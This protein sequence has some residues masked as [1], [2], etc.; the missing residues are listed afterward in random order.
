MLNGRGSALAD[1]AEVLVLAGQRAEATVEL[2]RAIVLYE[3]K[4]N[5]V[6]AE[7]LRVRLEK[8]RG[9]GLTAELG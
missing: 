6:S 9:V 4:G 1:L 8:L 5:V 7:K 2:D 3:R